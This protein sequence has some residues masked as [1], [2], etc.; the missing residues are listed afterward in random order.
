MVSNVHI[1][2]DI[3][4]PQS[5]RQEFIRWLGS[6]EVHSCEEF[7]PEFFDRI[8]GDPL[9]ELPRFTRPNPIYCPLNDAVVKNGWAV[10]ESGQFYTTYDYFHGAVSM[11][12][13]IIDTFFNPREIKLVGSI[14]GV[15]AA[16]PMLYVY[17]VGN[18]TI[19]LDV[20]STADYILEYQNMFEQPDAPTQMLRRLRD[21]LD[22]DFTL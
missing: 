18:G 4:V 3:C 16:S 17:D 19:E 10:N 21:E 7:V 11:M 12:S 8:W 15:N 22:L 13:Y 9:T 5:V 14:V 6:V 1:R 2:T 20:D